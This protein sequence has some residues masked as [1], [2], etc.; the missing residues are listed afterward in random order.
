MAILRTHSMMTAGNWGISWPAKFDPFAW[1]SDLG[2]SHPFLFQRQFP[3]VS[4]YSILSRLWVGRI[5]NL[6]LVY[7]LSDH[8]D[9]NKDMMEDLASRRIPTLSWM[10]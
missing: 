3:C 8:R 7:R 4:H 9:P 5:G 6:P 2:I 1:S 10:Q